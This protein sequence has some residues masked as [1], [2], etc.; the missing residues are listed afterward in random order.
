MSTLFQRPIGRRAVLKQGVGLL[1]APF[2][3]PRIGL[4]AASD[5]I[6]VASIGIGI[7]GNGN[8]R[9]M[10]SN[11]D[12]QLVAVC[13]VDEWR[14][15]DARDTVETAYA[16]EMKRGNYKG[17][18]ATKDFRE[19]LARPDIDAVLI[20]TGDRW[21]AVISTMA[22]KAG[23]DVYCE[24]PVS[25]TIHESRVM[26]D[27]F[28]RHNRILQGGF[29][30]RS[31]DDFAA[32]RR[33]IQNGRIG[34]LKT[35]YCNWYGTSQV[36][37]LPPET[38]PPGLDWDMWLGPAP[39]HPFNSRYHPVGQRGSRTVPWDI[40]RDF[41]G[42]SITS[43]G[44]HHLDIAQWVL[45]MDDSGPVEIVPG[46]PERRIIDFKYANG[47]LVQSFQGQL[48]PKFQEIPD[49]FDPATR[50]QWQI[51]F[52]GDRGWIVAGREGPL[53][54]SN[55]AIL[56]DVKLT[57]AEPLAKPDAKTGATSPQDLAEQIYRARGYAHHDNWIQAIRL[58]S[59]PVSNVEAATRST[60]VGHL[61]NIATW[62][63]RTQKWDPVKEEFIGDDMAN[64][65]RQRAMRA[66]W[67]I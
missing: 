11:P 63:G 2:I 53:K 47:V 10:L 52:V 64:R 35:I 54:A 27:T 55:P 9:R 20:A 51:L 61:G 59:Q 31:V 3:L 18:A 16:A 7:M 66:P 65:M 39:Y 50:F 13:D 60:N 1:V 38:P 32:A 58:R 43:N 46:T 25:L 56:T 19:I 6:N 33:L 24:K 36:L 57:P 48:N 14:L 17:V 15:N 41:A 40:Q 29:Q 26:V 42:G 8:M 67:T 62:T 28:R 49:G 30:Q 5:R 12:I 37:N 22:A 45:G 23:K 44:V 4:K 34:K 21:H